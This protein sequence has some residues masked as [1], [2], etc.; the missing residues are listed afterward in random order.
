MPIESAITSKSLRMTNNHGTVDGKVVRKTRTYS[1]VKPDATDESIMNVYN[2]ID[3]LQSAAAEICQ[4]VTTT[5]L[6]EV[7]L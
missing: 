4:V 7:S 6:T 5:Q 1:Y 3:S 2:T